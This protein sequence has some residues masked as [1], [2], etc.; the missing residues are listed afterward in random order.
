VRV[1]EYGLAVALLLVGGLYEAVFLALTNTTPGM[2]YARIRLCTL[3][4]KTPTRA[5]LNARLVA[6]P[7]SILPV[8]LG[9]I[10]SIFDD[11]RLTWHD[12]LSQTYLRKC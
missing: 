1:I 3:E 6:L 9:V 5:Q 2:W 11:D 8:G 10:W 4:G 7:L 12:R